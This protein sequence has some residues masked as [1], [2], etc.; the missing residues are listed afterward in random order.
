MPSG[1]HPHE[2]VDDAGVVLIPQAEVDPFDG[3][4]APAQRDRATH[5]IVVGVGDLHDPAEHRQPLAALPDLAVGRGLVLDGDRIAYS[6]NNVLRELEIDPASGR[7]VPAIHKVLDGQ[8][9]GDFFMI[10]RSQTNYDPAK[11]SLPAWVSNPDPAD[12]TPDAP[13]QL[14]TSRRG[15]G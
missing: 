14:W 1:Q 8:T 4:L 15:C 7:Y 6:T 12:D 10:P 3:G 13:T 5:E 9:V 2:G 11:H